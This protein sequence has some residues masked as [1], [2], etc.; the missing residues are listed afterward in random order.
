MSCLKLYQ[1]HVKLT[2]GQKMKSKF[3]FQLSDATVLNGKKWVNKLALK[4]LDNVQEKSINHEE[5]KI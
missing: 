2:N 4:I 3:F 5:Q 1:R